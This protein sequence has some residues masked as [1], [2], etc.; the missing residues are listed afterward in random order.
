MTEK[1]RKKF[2]KLSKPL[3]KFINDK[4]NP[5]TKIIIDCDSAE[6]VVGEAS[7]RTDEFIKD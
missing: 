4:F 6:I 2:E 1:D 5:H 7:F 3:I